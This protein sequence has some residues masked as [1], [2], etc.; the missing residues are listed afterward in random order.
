MLVPIEL[1]ILARKRGYLSP[2]LALGWRVGGYARE[3]FGNL[4]DIRIAVADNDDAK[5]GLE[6]MCRK[7]QFAFPPVLSKKPGDWDF[8]ICHDA[9]GTVLEIRTLA[10]K[11]NLPNSALGLER[12]FNHENFGCRNSS[13]ERYRIALDSLILDILNTPLENYCRIIE[14]RYRILGPGHDGDPLKLRCRRCTQIFP[15]RKLV[16]ISGVICCIDCSGLEKSWFEW[17]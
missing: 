17:N 8:L 1:N 10:E 7:L 16:E 12:N 11:V 6:L 4:E 3:F 13:V 2:E 9:T 5:L 15:R 14:K